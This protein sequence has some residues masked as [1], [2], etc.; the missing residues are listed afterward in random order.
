MSV[1]NNYHC[2]DSP[3]I[4]QSVLPLGIFVVQLRKKL[5]RE[6]SSIFPT[7]EQL[8]SSKCSL[9]STRL[10]THAESTVTVYVIDGEPLFFDDDGT[11][12]P[13]G[14]CSHISRSTN[15]Q[16][17]ALYMLNHSREVY[18]PNILPRPSSEEL[19]C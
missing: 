3:I 14:I 8:L 5:R 1:S 12:F 10:V 6:I 13:T 17:D 16:I 4:L 7:S 2:L 9:T 18:K 11:L 19:C 15:I